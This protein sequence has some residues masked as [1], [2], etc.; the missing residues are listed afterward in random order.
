MINDSIYWRLNK[1][2]V[3]GSLPA[4]QEDS[5]TLDLT[6]RSDMWSYFYNLSGYQSARDF[7]FISPIQLPY[8]NMW[9]SSETSL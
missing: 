1:D 5:K 7:F 3:D 4:N 9:V 2:W 8:S 6:C